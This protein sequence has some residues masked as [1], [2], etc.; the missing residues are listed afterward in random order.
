[1]PSTSAVTISL[2]RRDALGLVVLLAVGQ[3]D[4]EEVDFAILRGDLARAIDQHAGI[5]ELAGQLRVPLHDAAAM[6][7]HVMPARHLLQTL[8]ERTGH[9]LRNLIESC[10][11]TEIGPVFGQAGELCSHV[12]RPVQQAL[13]RRQVLLRMIAR[14][15]LNRCYFEMHDLISSSQVICRASNRCKQSST[16]ER[17]RQVRLLEQQ[18]FL[19]LAFRRGHTPPGKERDEHGLLRLECSCI[20]LP[21]SYRSGPDCEIHSSAFQK[22]KG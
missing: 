9:G 15:D 13:N 21:E 14:V 20:I 12:R 6:H 7:D 19:I 10:V 8:D 22:V 4:I 5:V 11:G 16:P 2:P 18:E 1:M 17:Q 3:V